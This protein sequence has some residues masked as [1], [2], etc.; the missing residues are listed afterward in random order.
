MRIVAALLIF[1]LFSPVLRPLAHA[2]SGEKAEL[3]SLSGHKE[4]NDNKACPLNNGPA[5]KECK[6]HGHSHE[7]GHKCE[8]FIECK[9]KD[10]DHS[11]AQ[12]EGAVYLVNR[13]TLQHHRFPRPLAAAGI[14]LYKSPFL[15]SQ[16]KPPA[17]NTQLTA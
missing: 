5:K 10:G 13:I 7:S 3:C 1:A 6:L 11:L 8:S 12:A 16:D 2:F 9:G 4:C 14:G 17:A 15:K